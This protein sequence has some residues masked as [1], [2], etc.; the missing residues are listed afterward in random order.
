MAAANFSTQNH[1]VPMAEP[2]WF[3]SFGRTPT[4]VSHTSSSHSPMMAARI[5]K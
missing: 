5:G 3:D 2:S 1:L 4:R